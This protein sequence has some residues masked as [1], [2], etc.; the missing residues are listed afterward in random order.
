VA[1]ARLAG[2]TRGRQRTLE[3][4]GHLTTLRQGILIET[5]RLQQAD[6]NELH[7]I[8]T[9]AVLL[10]RWP[11]RHPERVTWPEII[12]CAGHRT[13]AMF[14]E[15]RSPPPPVNTRPLNVSWASPAP[16][17]HIVQ[18]VSPDRSRRNW[19]HGVHVRPATLVKEDVT[20]HIG[21][22][23]TTIE[24]TAV[25][26][27]RELSRRDALIALDS[28]LAGGGSK[29]RMRAVAER[30]RGWRG[31][32][33]AEELIEFADGRSESA[34]ESWARLTLKDHGMPIPD[35]Q[36]DLSDA[37]GPVA[38]VD[39]IY[40]EHRTIVE[41]DGMIK[42]TDPWIDPREVLVR[43]KLREDR[44]RDAG[45][46]VVRVTWRQLEREPLAFID[47]V[48]RAFARARHPVR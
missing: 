12:F 35:L 42:Y 23:M 32:R 19:T 45:W 22:L 20:A 30:L 48:R 40:R 18:L 25:D 39:L 13:A 27:A 47:R 44:L 17:R 15:L 31:I 10:L 9:E 34:T 1:Q 33:Q 7:R 46:E 5:E 38:R 41:A 37:Q 4:N 43:E 6:T 16:T 29:E 26:L 3:K 21:L 2:L 24:R 11:P 28:A 14:W 36:V 8:D